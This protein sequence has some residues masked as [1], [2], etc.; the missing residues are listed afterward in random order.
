[1]AL[2]GAVASGAPQSEAVPCSTCDG[3]ALPR[4][5]PGRPRVR[6]GQAGRHPCA[7][8]R[9]QRLRDRAALHGGSPGHPP[10]LGAHKGHTHSCFHPFSTLEVQRGDGVLSVNLPSA[11]VHSLAT[12]APNVAFL[13]VCQM[14][15]R[16]D[17]CT[18]GVL[19]L[20]RSED[21]SRRFSMDLQAHRVQ[22]QYKATY[23]PHLLAPQGWELWSITSP[24]GLRVFCVMPGAHVRA[25]GSW[26]AAGPPHVH[27]WGSRHATCQGAATTMASLVS[28]VITIMERDV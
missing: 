13:G 2:T 7:V 19:L 16:L 11:A 24:A 14:L 25:A 27:R 20:G 3:L 9:E 1:M 22:K 12:T 28:A 8:P 26:G 4:P 5:P 10:P 6:G 18:T 23:L 21:A 15:H 17:V